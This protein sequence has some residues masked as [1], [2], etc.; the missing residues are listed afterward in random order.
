[1]H[2]TLRFLNVDDPAASDMYQRNVL[3]KKGNTTVS[4]GTSMSILFRYHNFGLEKGVTTK[5]DKIWEILLRTY[6]EHG[7]KLFC[8]FDKIVIQT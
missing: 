5:S 7:G 2:E 3:S 1:M 4:Q 8:C 6:S